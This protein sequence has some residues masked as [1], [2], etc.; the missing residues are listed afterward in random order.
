MDIV[1]ASDKLFL[2]GFGMETLDSC[3]N[4]CITKFNNDRLSDDEVTCL[5]DCATGK[6]NQY[7]EAS[8]QLGW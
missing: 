1:A 8:I 3:F 2:M 4:S 6:L 5:K 7:S